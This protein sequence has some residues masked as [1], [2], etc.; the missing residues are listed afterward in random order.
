MITGKTKII[1]IFGHPIEHSMSPL[2]HNAAFEALG[3]DYIYIPFAIEPGSLFQA[4]E[5]IRSLNLVGVNVTIPHKEIIIPYLDEISEEAKLIGAVNVIVN[6]GDR[7]VGLN[8]DGHG[9]VTSLKTEAKTDPKNKKIVV[10]GAGGAARAVAIQLAL[11]GAEEI[12]ILNRNITKAQEIAD[13]INNLGG[14]QAYALSLNEESFLKVMGDTNILINSTPIG[15]Y[16]KHNVTTVINKE[17]LHKDLLVCDL[18]YNPLETTLLREAK[19][20]GCKTLQGTGML[21]FQGALAFEHWIGV[22][23]PVEVMYQALL[24]NLKQSKDSSIMG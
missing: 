24:Q 11:E 8:T 4:T 6:K 16:P 15:M 9:F 7:L 18:I 14:S 1:G 10:L 5:A 12:C 22:K 3:L 17:F 23:A 13:V 19:E 21:V 2:M 20:L